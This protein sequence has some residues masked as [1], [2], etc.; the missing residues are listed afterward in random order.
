[1]KDK[2]NNNVNG[3]IEWIDWAKVILIYLMVVGHNTPTENTFRIIYAFHM[4]A[5]FIISGYLYKEHSWRRTIKTFGIP[6]IVF[7]SINLLIYLLINIQHGCLDFSHFIERC[8]IPFWGGSPKALDYIILFP[9]CWFIL[10]LFA[11]RLFIG[12]IHGLGFVRRYAKYVI[13]VLCAYI[14]IESFLF[15]DNPLINY[16]FYRVVVSLPFML[17]GVIIKEKFTIKK[18]SLWKGILLLLVFILIALK[19]GKCDMLHYQFGYSYLLFYVNATIGSIALFSIC[20]RLR[21]HQCVQVL[22]KGT[23]FVLAFNFNLIIFL[24]VA[25][26]KLGFSAFVE[27]RELYSW[28]G[29]IVILGISYYPIKWMLKHYP[30]VLG[31]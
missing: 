10:S 19:Q 11:G 17:L 20:S 31:K 21:P 26:S 9:G 16:K 2:G 8:L 30:T 28:I 12:D 7:S 5:F 24:R 1:M 27:N 18:M 3:K 13:C 23:L 4:P 22:S 29:G 6:L 14:M 25:L 15:P